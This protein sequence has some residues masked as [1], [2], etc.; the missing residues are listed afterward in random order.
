MTA[1]TTTT[2]STEY[3]LG[4]EAAELARLEHQA[5]MLAPA[6]RTILELAGIEPGMRVLDLGTGAGDVAFQ[7]A[8][9]VGPAGSVVGVDQSA[10]ALGFAAHRAE[11]RGIAN[12]SF[13]H[14]DLHT[15]RLAERFDAVVGR[16]VLLYLPE[17]AAVLRRF[18]GFVRPGGVIAMMEFEMAA[19]GTLPPTPLSDQ[20]NYWVTEA[21]YRSGLDASLGA[22]LVKVLRH[23]GLGEP[24]V[25][26]VQEYRQPDNRDGPRMASGILRTLLPV[27]ERTGIATAAEVDVDTIEDRLALDCVDHDAIFRLPTLVGAWARPA[28]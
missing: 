11:Q 13:V 16:L 17:P 1:S 18:A 3:L 8:E 19:A 23:A 9:L 12:V 10:K 25:L 26:G 20:M 6:T 4:H 14:E 22:R 5:S 2:T 28:A 7:V 21:F 24:T 27:L 15:I